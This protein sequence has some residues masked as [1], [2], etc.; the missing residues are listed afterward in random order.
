MKRYLAVLALLA[1]GA[2]STLQTTT[3]STVKAQQTIDLAVAAYKADLRAEII[4][5]RLPPCGITGS[6]PKPLCA[7]YAVAAKWKALDT[8][9]H[10]AITTAQVRLDAVGTDPKVIDAAVAAIE[11]VLAE[12]ETFTASEVK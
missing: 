12:I 9:L 2:C 11:V 7:S 4:Y 6:P 10:N 8:K 5:L 1:L 3:V